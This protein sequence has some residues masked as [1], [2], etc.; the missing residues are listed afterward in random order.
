MARSSSRKSEVSCSLHCNI[1]I[2]KANVVSYGSGLSPSP[3][4]PPGTKVLDDL[5]ADL[6]PASPLPI[7]IRAT[8]GNSKDKRKDKIK[9]STVVE[10]DALERFY[11]RY[12]EV[13]KLGMQGLRKRDRSGRKKGKAKKRKGVVEGDK[14]T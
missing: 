7:I 11:T 5:L 9:L 3:S 2:L 1:S 13:C 6:H 12:A 14:K 10:A 8:D 4:P